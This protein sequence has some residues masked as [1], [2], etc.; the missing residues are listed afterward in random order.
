MSVRQFIV[1]I[2]LQFIQQILTTFYA[3]FS[4]TTSIL[5]LRN[6][7]YNYNLVI[8]VNRSNKMKK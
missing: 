6:L 3:I 7:I 4:V 8:A 2:K 1:V 5:V